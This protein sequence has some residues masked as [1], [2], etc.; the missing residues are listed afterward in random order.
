M[1]HPTTA[2]GRWPGALV[3][4]VG[5]AGV[6]ACS[7]LDSGSSQQEVGFTDGSGSGTTVDAGTG[8]GSGSGSGSLCTV[9]I[10]NASES[11]M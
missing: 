7:Q 3:T 2:P 8:S 10:L 5:L 11:P 6:P 1:S 9:T 4:L